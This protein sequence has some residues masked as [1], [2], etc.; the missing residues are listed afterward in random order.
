M[1]AED[2]FV[3]LA[4]GRAVPAKD[5]DNLLAAFRIVHAENPRARLWIA[6]ERGKAPLGPFDGPE[7]GESNGVRWLGL[8]N[9]MPATI[10][11]ADAFVLSSAWEG[12]PLVVGEAMAME[13]PVVATDVGGVRELMGDA[14]LIVPAK[15]PDALAAAMLRIMHIS[16]DD[17]IAMGQAGRARI[18]RHFD[19][20]AKVEEWQALYEHLLGNRRKHVG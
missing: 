20:R 9:N 18:C 8:R 13:K 12:M 1:C 2:D 15:D 16:K 17:R 6:G 3:W 14:G 5:F 10:A 11:A 7:C 4:A 19:M